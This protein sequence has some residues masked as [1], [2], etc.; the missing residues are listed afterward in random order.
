MDRTRPLRWR[1]PHP[2]RNPPRRRRRLVTHHTFPM[3]PE[4]KIRLSDSLR[5]KWASGTRKPNPPGTGK[6]AATTNKARGR[7]IGVAACGEET[8]HA[9]AKHASSFVI[10]G[11][12]HPHGRWWH[13]RDPQGVPHHFRN[14]RDFV[15]SNPHLFPEGDAE[16]RINP[17]GQ[18]Y[19]RASSGLQS[20][21]RPLRQRAC[22]S[23]KGWT[24]IALCEEENDILDRIS[25]PPDP[26]ASSPHPSS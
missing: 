18:K 8:R 23:W 6:K 15:R 17:K 20:L 1:R 19:M 14:L 11:T 5:K 4:T 26:A 22:T 25:T 3:T 10:Q 9:M 24:L 21:K 13:V 16:I 7:P 12:Q 2:R